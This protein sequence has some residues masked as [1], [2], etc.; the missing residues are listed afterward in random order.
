MP[1]RTYV[2]LGLSTRG[3]KGPLSK[4]VVVPLVPPPPPPPAP[5]FTYD[6][7]AVSLTW[8]PVAPP[9]APEGDQLPSRPLGTTL[10]T[11][12][13]NVYD[14]SNPG[15]VVKL[16]PKPLEATKYSDARIVWGQK[17]CYTIVAAETIDGATIESEA[18][19]PTCNTLVD[20][21]PPAASQGSQI[22]FR[23]GRHQ[24]D[25]G[26]QRREGSRGVHRVPRCRTRSNAR[27][28]H[29]R[30]NRRAVVQGQCSA[31]HRVR[32][33]RSRRRPGRQ[34]ERAH[35]RAWSTPPADRMSG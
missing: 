19:P 11:I 9:G 3:R 2:A 26:T 29:R 16:T 8:S 21:F 30:A 33:R 24:P 15:A 17:R 27:A 7:T 13:Y 35:R 25:L 4:R 28:G 12:G 6:E 34:R 32:I 10:P 22:D 18:P 1:V 20:T 31:G 5:A 23:R 14:A